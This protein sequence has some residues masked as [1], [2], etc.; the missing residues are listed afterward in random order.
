MGSDG[1][2]PSIPAPRFQG[3]RGCALDVIPRGRP[4]RTTLGM[5]A[6]DSVA[7]FGGSR[8]GRPVSPSMLRRIAA[9]LFLLLGLVALAGAIALS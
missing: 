4:L 5:L 2:E 7:V 9:A 1:R 6:A 8:P 3:A